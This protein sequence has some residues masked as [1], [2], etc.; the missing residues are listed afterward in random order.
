MKQYFPIMK[1]LV[2]GIVFL[3][4]GTGII[5]ITAQ[6]SGKSSLPMLRGNWLYVGGSGPGNYSKIQDAIDN[7]SDG[8]TVFVFSGTYNETIVV[9]T[10]LTL[11]GESKETTM[12]TNDGITDIVTLNVGS[13]ILHGFT[14]FNE[15]PQ[16]HSNGITVNSNDNIISYNIIGTYFSKA[17]CLYNAH[18]N[19]I[20]NNFIKNT[21]NIGIYIGDADRNTI[22]KNRITGGLDGIHMYF[23]SSNNM[24]ISNHID[25]T[26][27]GVSFWSVTQQNNVSSNYFEYNE[28]DGIDFN[29]EASNNIVYKNYFVKNMGGVAVWGNAQSNKILS[30]TFIKNA[31]SSSYFLGGNNTNV[32]D[33]N[34]WS[35]P[36]I[37]PKLVVGFALYP[38]HLAF[39]RHPAK[40]PYDIP[41]MN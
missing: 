3:F 38:P 25:N 9:S 41:D 28:A 18:D 27:H 22:Q 24:I 8:D 39:D 14:I 34:Y 33:G 37:L 10:S 31:I 2:A 21:Y 19:L 35:I 6:D 12:I 17:V 36:R 26:S 32:W 1:C 5:P 20:E 40:K 16:T 7:A 29:D 11:L 23:S 4:V 30:N 15:K 13:C